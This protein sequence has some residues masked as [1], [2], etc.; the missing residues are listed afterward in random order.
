MRSAF[1]R[2]RQGPGVAVSARTDRALCPG[3]QRGACIHKP[4]ADGYCLVDALGAPGRPCRRLVKQIRSSIH[5]RRFSFRGRSQ[6]LPMVKIGELSWLQGCWLR[7]VDGEGSE[8]VWFPPREGT[9]LGMRWS[10]RGRQPKSVNELRVVRHSHGVPVLDLS[11]RGSVPLSLRLVSMGRSD[12][13]FSASDD[14]ACSGLHYL[15]LGRT[16]CVT[17]FDAAGVRKEAWKRVA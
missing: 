15:R 1:D 16:L 3:T 11:Y 12:V 13:L 8:E 4:G 6:Y 2:C 14:G 17:C 9:M 7:E 10:I 5:A